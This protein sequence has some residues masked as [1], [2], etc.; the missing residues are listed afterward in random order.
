MDKHENQARL[1]IYT[2]SHVI[3]VLSKT[4]HPF[5]PEISGLSH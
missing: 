3:K 4:V 1:Y 2:F 5:V